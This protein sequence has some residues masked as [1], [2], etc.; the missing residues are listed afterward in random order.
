MSVPA[1]NSREDAYVNAVVTKEAAWIRFRVDAILEEWLFSKTGE[2]I[3]DPAGFY[4]I[5]SSK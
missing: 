2:K 3:P 4:Y 5:K 1:P